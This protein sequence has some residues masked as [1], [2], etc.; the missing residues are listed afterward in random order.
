MLRLILA[1]VVVALT[2]T[3]SHAGCGLLGKLFGGRCSASRPAVQACQQCQQVPTQYVQPVSYATPVISAPAC[4]NGQCAN[5][6]LQV[7]PS[8]G[9]RFFGR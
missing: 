1:G 9:Y 7:G 8:R 3:Q 5:Q 2:A 4:A 6:A